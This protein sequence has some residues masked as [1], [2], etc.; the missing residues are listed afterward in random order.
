MSYTK[1]AVR[2]LAA[3]ISIS[4][5]GAQLRGRVPPPNAEA[6]VKPLRHG[7]SSQV[8]EFENGEAGSLSRSIRQILLLGQT[9]LGFESFR[10][11]RARGAI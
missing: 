1:Q 10:V 6:P 4:V 3:R 8:R 7:A 9:V 2:S 5:E 11:L